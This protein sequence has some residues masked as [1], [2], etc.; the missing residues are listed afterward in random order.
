MDRG[1]GVD[2]ITKTGGH[3]CILTYGKTPE[4]DIPLV[5][6][7]GRE[8]NEDIPATPDCGEYRFRAAPYCGLW[9]VAF[10]LLGSQ[11][12][13]LRSTAELKKQAEIANSCP[14][15]FADALPLTLRHAARNKAALR[16]AISDEAIEAHVNAVFSHRHLISRVR[17]VIL[18]GLDRSFDRSVKLYEERC[19]ERGIPLFHL[20]FFYPTN[21][22][23]IRD[24]VRPELRGELAEVLAA[25]D[26]SC[27]AGAKGA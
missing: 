2:Q 5:L 11:G 15:I 1:L 16:A 8:P 25:F 7:V 14:L 24:A 21:T 9:N 27:P 18:S 6:V 3:P 4:T 26:R 22:R 17:V 10:G 13:P 20:P 12:V 23:K 19:L